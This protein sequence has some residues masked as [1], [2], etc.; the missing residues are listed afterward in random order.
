MELEFKMY[1]KDFNNIF[2]YCQLISNLRFNLSRSEGGERDIASFQASPTS[3]YYPS[4]Y[5]WVIERALNFLPYNFILI[6]I[7]NIQIKF[8]MC[9]N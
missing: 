4:D 3:F 8:K 2:L 6:F 1:E 7:T 5:H 9:S